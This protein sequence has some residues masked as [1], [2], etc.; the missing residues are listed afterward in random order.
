MKFYGKVFDA[1]ISRKPL[2]ENDCKKFVKV[3]YVGKICVNYNSH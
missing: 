2:W 1:E 3:R